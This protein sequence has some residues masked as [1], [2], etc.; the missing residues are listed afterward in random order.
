MSVVSDN[1]QVNP[2]HELGPTLQAFLPAAVHGIAASI[3]AN[4]NI[5]SNVIP[6]NGWQKG[7]IGISSTEA[8]NLSAQRYVDQAGTIPIGAVITAAITANT[9]LAISWSDGLPYGSFQVTVT[10]TTGVVA[11]LSDVVVL[12]Q[13]G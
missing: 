1:A 2:A 7:A 8:G 12:M 11:N 6:S 9:P 10:N 4:G 3:P 5:K 13:G